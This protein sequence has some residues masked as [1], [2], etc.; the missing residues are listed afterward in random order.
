MN[1]QHPT[2]AG[3][4]GVARADITPP[5]GI[6]HRNW[7]AATHETAEGV[8]RPLTATVLTLQSDEG[9]APLVLV[10]ADLGWW[11]GRDDE[12]HVRGGILDALGLDPARVMVC[13]THTH[14]GPVLSRADAD[15][16][17]GDLIAPYLDHL[18]ATLADL[19]RRALAT[20]RPATLTV[21]TGRCTV[22]ANRDLPAPPIAAGDHTVQRDA[23]ARRAGE[24]EATRYLTGFA[25]DGPPADDTLLVGRV[26]DDATGETVA[27]LVNYA[28]HPT[29]LAHEN[30]LLSPDFVGALREVVEGANGGAPCAFLQGASGELAPREQYTAD[31]SV[32]DAHGRAIGYAVLSTLA[33]M[34]PPRTG[35]AY[36]GS[37]ESGAPLALW[38]RAPAEPP[39]GTDA[40]LLTVELPLK[41]LPTLAEIEAELARTT[42]TY[43]AERLRRRRQVRRTVGDGDALEYPV[44]VW[45]AGAL[46]FVGHPGEAYSALQ[47]ELRAAAGLDAAV[48]VMNVVNG[49]GGYLPPAD[50]YDRDL[51]AVWQTPLAAGCLEKV[52]GA[53]RDALSPCPS[54]AAGEGGLPPASSRAADTL[55][56]GEAR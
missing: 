48:F 42:D 25:P 14:A 16:P 54:P 53:A 51:Y 40:R 15:R 2:F 10:S 35:L 20:A 23:G 27:T 26:T 41:P 28:C 30:R 6:Y 47:T 29:T 46:S 31:T 34:L 37:V 52:I 13:L 38:R 36:A 3:R 43:Q 49:W 55:E 5:V 24:I 9:D 18:R 50:F 44:W 45:R 11:R 22:A 19:V 21:S 33:Q 7:G 32:A 12:A 17:G 4:I 1:V 39:T 8:H 56:G